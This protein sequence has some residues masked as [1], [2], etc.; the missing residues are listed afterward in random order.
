MNPVCPPGMYKLEVVIESVFMDPLV[1]VI[2]SV[3]ILGAVMDPVKYV[4]VAE[5]KRFPVEPVNPMNPVYPPGMYMLDVVIESVFMDPL[6]L[7]IES[8]IILGAVMDPV[9]YVFVAETKRFPVEPVNPMN[10][11]YPPGMY[12]LDVVIES[13]FMDPLVLVIESVII[14]GAVMDP[15]K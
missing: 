3:I 14:L 7:V 13:V 8:V 15:V 5:T 1:L 9:K 4:F 11:V 10:P 12:M 6:V 2:E